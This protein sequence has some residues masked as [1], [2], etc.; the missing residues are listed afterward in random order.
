MSKQSRRS[1]L[2]IA[3]STAVVVAASH[4]ALTRHPAT[5]L[6]PWQ[7]AGQSYTDPK[8]RA[9][10]FAILAPNPHNLQPWL[11]DLKTPNQITLY[12]DLERL[13]PETDPFN[14]QIVI[15]LGC[16]L[17]TLHLAAAEDGYSIEITPFPEGEPGATVDRKPIAQIKFEKNQSSP[18]S[19]FKQVLTRRS[20]KEPFDPARPVEAETL[21][22]LHQ[23]AMPYAVAHTSR[24]NSQVQQLRDLGWRAHQIEVKTPRTNQ[25]SIDVMRIGKAEI[26]ANPDGIDL[27]GV[28]LETLNHVGLFTRKQ[29]ADPKSN[30]FQ[31]GLDLYSKIHQTSMAYLWLVTE[32][33]S[34]TEQL[35]VGR[36]WMR[37]SLA[38]MAQGLSIHPI[39]QA[40][41]EYPEMKTTYDELRA[42]L[43][44][45]DSQ[46]IQ[47]LARLGYGPQVPPSPRWPLVTRI[48]SP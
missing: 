5:A 12:C 6:E 18:D 30:T 13:L 42:L 3:G 26:Q 28:M 22:I 38:A 31:Q 15:G 11:V 23:A 4:Y 14:R 24:D 33:N 8:M 43:D 20:T 16:F 21:A 29:L 25:E 48:V 9:L 7:Q 45:R 27:G 36:A 34:R 1:F 32:T 41:Q 19:L 44:I 39:S 10:S 46:R 47:M 37:V 35:A 40:L 2:R 17:E